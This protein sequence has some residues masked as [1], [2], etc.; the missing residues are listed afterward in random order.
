V[1][2]RILNTLLLIVLPASFVA[3]QHQFQRGLIW[4][5]NR[6]N[7]L[8]VSYGAQVTVPALK[9]LKT[10]YPRVIMEPKQDMTGVAWAC[11][12]YGRTAAEAIA[13][14]LQEPG[15]VLQVAF[16]PAYN[17]G[18]VR[19]SN[20]CK[21]AISMI[22]LMESMVKNGSPFWSEY[23][24]FCVAQVAPE[25]YA[26]A[27]SKRLSG[28]VKLFNTSDAEAIK[29]Q[30][31]KRALNSHSPVIIGMICPP[32]FQLASEFWQPREQP[33]P[34]HGGHAI[35]VVGYDDTKYGGAFELVNSWGKGWGTQ[36]YSWIRYKDFADFTPYAF[37]LFQVGGASCAT[38]FEGE[39]SFRDVSGKNMPA[40]NT[41][42]EG[43]YQ[44]TQSYP[45]GTQFT[46]VMN[47]SRPAYV[48]SFGVDPTNT[49]F[50]MFPRSPATLPISFGPLKAPDD[51]PVLQLTDPPGRNVIYFVFSPAPIDLNNCI[52]LLK[53]AGDFAPRK[54]ESVLSP[55]QVTGTQWMPSK[56]GFTT[57]LTS[58]VAVKV[59]LNQK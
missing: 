40:A 58:P 5:D 11:L 30:A 9:S 55:T 41:G 24:E 49:F 39:V 37:S 10:F 31:V 48:Y 57:S 42:A 16:S 52:N 19:K 43:E 17:Y 3:G 22:D 15:K 47:S 13:C 21:E 2:R 7:T 27:R 12:W 51:M 33:D 46:I 50:P 53:S 25:V 28:Y 32:S 34:Q 54:I 20:D 36:G 4:E 29:V 59:V 1:T 14:N 44:L 35:N 6:Y 26:T 18:L 56:V 23:R 45:S 38:P 8:P